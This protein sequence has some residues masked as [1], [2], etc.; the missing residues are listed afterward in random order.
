MEM[1]N[2]IKQIIPPV[3]NKEAR[4]FTSNSATTVRQ[5]TEQ[6]KQQLA[7]LIHFE[8]SV[9]RHLDWR[10]PL[11]WLGHS[12]YLVAERNGS[13]KAALACPPD[14]P[15]VSWIRMFAVSSDWTHEAAWDALWP[16][17]QTELHARRIST[18]A[19]IPLQKWFQK[20]LENHHF[21]HIHNVVLM[22]WQ[23]GFKSISPATGD[24]VIRSMNF[25]DLKQVEQ[26]DGSAFGSIWRNSLDGLSIAFQQA[27]VASV[28]E[29]DGRMVG[30]QIS[31]GNP[32]GGHL[33]RLAINPEFH[34]KGIGYA[35]VKDLLDQFERRGAQRVTVNTQQDNLI[36]LALYKKAGFRKTDEVY[37]VY[38]FRP[39]KRIV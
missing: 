19:A 37:P 26:L 33:A 29:V 21:Q 23:P 35:M 32:T 4:R 13:I 39:V 16:A 22:Y 7:N 31:T 27:A 25:D 6:D 24:L 20:I 10:A 1:K 8:T 15:D 12:P 3:G 28:A 5:V 17:A 30:Y 11:E 38:Q 36:S 18:V 2:R 14:P 9:H 34:H